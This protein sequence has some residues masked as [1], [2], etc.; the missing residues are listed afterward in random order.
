MRRGGGAQGYNLRCR[1]AHCGGAALP[2]MLRRRPS[3]LNAPPSARSYSSSPSP[4]GTP[5]PLPGAQ[6]YYR[7]RRRLPV[8]RRVTARRYSVEEGNHTLLRCRWETRNCGGA[9][10]RGF[11]E[12]PHHDGKRASFKQESIIS[13]EQIAFL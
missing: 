7:R 2:A 11:W 4:Y 13:K 5:V 10:Q 3:P 9:R 6:C 12:E 1:R 8:P